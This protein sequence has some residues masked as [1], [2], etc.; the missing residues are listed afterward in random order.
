MSWLTADA[1][2]RV[3]PATTARIV[4]EATAAMKPNRRGPPIAR[5]RWI[6]AMFGADQID[7]LVELPGRA[8]V[9]ISRVGHQDGDGAKAKDGDDK[10]EIGHAG[11]GIEY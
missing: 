9:E 2:A 4:A 3:N 10:A 8:N 7:D 5:A 11:A 1:P 6:A